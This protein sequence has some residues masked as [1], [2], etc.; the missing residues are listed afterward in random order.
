MKNWMDF[1]NSLTIEDFNSLCE[2]CKCKRAADKAVADSLL[3]NGLT[4]EENYLIAVDR[5]IDAI[6]S[7]RKRTAMGL[8]EAKE[9]V[10]N[11]KVVQTDDL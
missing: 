9:F 5:K 3:S 10:L 4:L 2:A 8:R 11:A 6:K 7:L 1:I